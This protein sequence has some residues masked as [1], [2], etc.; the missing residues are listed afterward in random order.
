[1]GNRTRKEGYKS[2]AIFLSV[3]NLRFLDNFTSGNLL[4]LSLTLVSEQLFS[5]E[6]TL[7]L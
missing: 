7:P 2:L 5:S 3:A 1:M 4:G 6:T